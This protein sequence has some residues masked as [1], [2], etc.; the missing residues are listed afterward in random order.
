MWK[1][2][3]CTEP[4][5]HSC[6]LWIC[7]TWQL[8]AIPISCESPWHRVDWI[9]SCMVD[10]IYANWEWEIDPL[11]T[12]VLSVA[13]NMCDMLCNWWRTN[14]G[15]WWCHISENWCLDEREFLLIACFLR[16][17][18]SFL[19]L[20][21]LYRGH[22]LSDSHELSLFLQLYNAH[23]WRNDTGQSHDE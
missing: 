21:T 7:C 18:V 19:T 13:R 16:W 4:A 17:N 3:K 14:V 12:P 15:F 11:S 22:G 23:P 2:R 5:T 6:P 10:H 20:I 9:G 1:S 8:C